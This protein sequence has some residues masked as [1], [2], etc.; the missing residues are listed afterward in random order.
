MGILNGLNQVSKDAN[1]NMLIT[2]ENSFF[3]KIL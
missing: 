1:G 2:Q 3:K